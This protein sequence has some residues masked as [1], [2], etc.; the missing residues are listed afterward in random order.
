M[1]EFLDEVASSAPT[2]GGG[3]VAALAGSLA[4]ALATMVA[5][6]TIGKKK[7]AEHD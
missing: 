6:L 3:S 4:G 2:P 5:R 7:Y 1:P